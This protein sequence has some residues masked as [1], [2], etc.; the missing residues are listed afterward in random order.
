MR[1]INSIIFGLF[2][3]RNFFGGRLLKLTTVGARSGEQR[4]ST[5]AYFPDVDGTSWIIIGSANGAAKH[6]AWMFNLAKH[7]DQVW[8]ELG[9]RKVKVTPVTLTGDE[10]AQTWKRVVAQA[11]SYAGYETKTDRDIPVVRLS[12]AAS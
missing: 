9:N 7:P 11:P 10:R 1:F 12:P 5:L 8:A 3:N 2:R 4:T 6:P